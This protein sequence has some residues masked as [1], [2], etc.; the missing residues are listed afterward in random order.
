MNKTLKELYNELDI[1]YHFKDFLDVH[2]LDFFACECCDNLSFNY[3]DTTN[4][5]V[6]CLGDYKDLLFEIEEREKE[7]K[8]LEGK[9]DD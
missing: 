7:V 5:F 1:L 2:N 4:Y 9:N 8:R 6:E 3:R